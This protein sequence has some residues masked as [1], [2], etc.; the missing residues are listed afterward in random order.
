MRRSNCLT[1]IAPSISVLLD[2]IF[3]SLQK[4]DLVS[5]NISE[6]LYKKL[7]CCR[8]P[9][10]L[11]A[12]DIAEEENYFTCPF[13]RDKLDEWVEHLVE[14]FMSLLA[15]LEI[16]LLNQGRFCNNSEIGALIAKRLSVENKVKLSQ[17]TWADFVIIARFT[18]WFQ[19]DHL[20]KVKLSQ[21]TWADFVIIGWFTHW[22]QSDYL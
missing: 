9:F 20:N 13:H 18:H 5:E 7:C 10:E 17:L 19:S 4:N 15:I 11:R 2:D 16:A 6:T 21:L 12:D 14:H 22:F 1:L 3:P 8:N